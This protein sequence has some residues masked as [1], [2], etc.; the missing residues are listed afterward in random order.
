MSRS[1]HLICIDLDG[2]ILDVSERYY[3]VYCDTLKPT[4]FEPLSKESYWDLKRKKVSEPEI[5]AQS[6]TPDDALMTAYLDDRARQ[7]ESAEYL[8]FDQVWPGTIHTLNALR[9]RHALALVT[10]R[11]SKELL[12][13]QLSELELIDEFDCILTPGPGLVA[14]DRGERKAQLVRDCY[15]NKEFTGWFIGDTETD[16]Q[17]GRLLGLH[18]AAI[19]FGIRTGE[20]L[21]AVSP[22]VM[23][24]SP[25]EF[26]IWAQNF[27]SQSRVE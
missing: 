8:R 18:T 25:G 24:Q 5:L 17:S 15:D 4:G 6:K 3:Q 1:L 2:P 14:N 16:I 27:S 19:T 26:R 13:Q 21:N 7:I 12:D 22:D 11:T 20:H 23:L 9:S 10:M